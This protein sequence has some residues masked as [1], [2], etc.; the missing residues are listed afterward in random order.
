VRPRLVDA[1]DGCV[2]FAD[3]TT[4][5][6]RVV[7]WATG[8]TADHSWIDIHSAL[9]GGPVPGSPAHVRGVSRVPGL[10]FLGL[11]WQHSRGSA[12]LGFVRHDAAWLAD[13]M[14]AEHAGL[15]RTG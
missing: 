3:G 11:P 4:L 15:P 1:A 6:P 14:H 8:F 9:T 12:L 2:R 5:S 10:Y 7:I 13:R